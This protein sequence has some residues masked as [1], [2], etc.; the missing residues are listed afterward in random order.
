V[1]LIL[2]GFATEAR[3]ALHREGWADSFDK[4]DVV[5]RAG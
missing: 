5:L 4:L 2:G 3:L 1:R